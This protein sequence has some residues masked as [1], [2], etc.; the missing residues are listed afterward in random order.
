MKVQVKLVPKAVT[1]TDWLLGDDT[2]CSS[3][4]ICRFMMGK[5]DY[6]PSIPHDADDFGRCYR[7]LIL[8]PQWLER[9][10]ELA[11][12]YSCWR[13]MVREWDKLTAM[14]EKG[15]NNQ[16]DGKG[17]EKMYEFMRKLVDEGYKKE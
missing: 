16:W 1:P 11:Q 6:S 13:P 7:L 10:P 9:L 17:W 2:G 12:K 3:E 14:Y 4:T 5:P 8:F 15:M